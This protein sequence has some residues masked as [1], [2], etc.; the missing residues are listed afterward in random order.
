MEVEVEVGI[1]VVVVLVLIMLVLAIDSIPQLLG[2]AHLDVAL[3]RLQLHARA[4][5][6]D[7]ERLAMLPGRAGERERKAGIDVAIRRRSSHGDVGALRYGDRDVP[8]VRPEAVGS[9]I[10]DG[11][12]VEHVSVD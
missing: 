8:V 4:A 6:A 7:L 3:E 1:M 2:T 5:R 12:L 11:P 9:A 10:L